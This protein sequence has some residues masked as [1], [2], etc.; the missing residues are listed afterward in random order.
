MKRLIV[1]WI[2][3]L[4]LLCVWVFSIQLKVLG[5]I[6]AP[7]AYGSFLVML[8]Y[9]LRL[10]L[11]FRHWKTGRGITVINAYLNF[12]IFAAFT[13]ISHT[14][15][16]YPGAVQMTFATITSPPNFLLFIG[17][18]LLIRWKKL[19]KQ[20]YWHH[21]KGNIWRAVAGTV[22]CVVLFYVFNMPASFKEYPPENNPM[23]FAP[24]AL[25]GGQVDIKDLSHPQKIQKETVNAY[26]FFKS[27]F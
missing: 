25:S 7:L 10:F 3:E 21:L 18:F 17:L 9:L 8:F 16:E 1:S 11:S 22:A 27:L 24:P 4:I 6:Q 15:L 26:G 12:Q 14:I 13:A 5:N 2:T 23:W 19:N 20:V